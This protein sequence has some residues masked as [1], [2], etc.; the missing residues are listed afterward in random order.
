[1]LFQL[2]WLLILSAVIIVL[3]FILLAVRH[4]MPKGYKPCAVCGAIMTTEL[5]L[6]ILT[7]ILPKEI[8]ILLMGSS[9]TGGAMWIYKELVVKGYDSPGLELGLQIFFTVAAL[10][11]V[12]IVGAYWGW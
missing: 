10:V 4:F 9:V 8:T 7:N 5:A 6:G 12:L 2:D 1:M 11:V 3:F